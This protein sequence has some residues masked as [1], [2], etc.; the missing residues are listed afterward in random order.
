MSTFLFS[1]VGSFGSEEAIE[2]ELGNAYQLEQDRQEKEE[3]EAKKKVIF[4]F[5][6]FFQFYQ[7]VS[8]NLLGFFGPIVVSICANVGGNYTEPLLRSSAV[9]ALT[10]F[11]CVSAEF[12]YLIFFIQFF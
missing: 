7:L 4:T 8:A 1:I 5:L 12:W 10:K 2:K 9:I 6:I 11:M 3:L